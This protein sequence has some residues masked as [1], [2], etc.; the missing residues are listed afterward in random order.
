MLTPGLKWDVEAFD[1]SDD[2][3]ILAYSVNEDGYSLVH[4][5]DL[6]TKRE[7]MQPKLP[8]GRA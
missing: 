5:R 3:R 6:K 4:I 8:V 2:G 7:L 1:V